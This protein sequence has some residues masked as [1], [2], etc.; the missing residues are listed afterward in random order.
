MSTSFHPQMDGATEWANRSNGQVLWAMVCNDKKDW[1][2]LCPMV[3]FTLNSNVSATTGYAPFELYCR[4]L[5]LLG[6]HNSINTK[7]ASVKQIA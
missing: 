5:P 7:Y 4:Y 6:Q 2:E 1:A 3:E